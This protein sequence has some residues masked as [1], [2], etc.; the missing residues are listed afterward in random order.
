MGTGASGLALHRGG[1]LL[2]TLAILLFLALGALGTVGAAS[3]GFESMLP[4]LG[5]PPP[6][7]PEAAATGAAAGGVGGCGDPAA[8]AARM[9]SEDGTGEA[10]RNAVALVTEAVSAY[11]SAAAAYG[12]DWAFLAGVGYRE[13]KHGTYRAPGCDPGPPITINEPGARGPMQF[14]GGTWRC[15]ADNRKLDVSGPPVPEGETGCYGTDGDGDGIADPWSWPDAAHSA[16]R[17][18]VDLGAQE[19]AP[20]AA[21][22]YFQGPATTRTFSA[23]HPYVK[24]VMDMAQRYHEVTADLVPAGVVLAGAATGQCPVA[25]QGDSAPQPMEQLT[26]A[27]QRMADA[28]AGCLGRQWGITCYDA[29]VRRGGKFEHPRGRACDFMLSTGP[30]ADA[31]QR[32]R[33]EA[34]AEWIAA[35]HE[36]LGILYVIWWD[37]SWKPANGI[38]PWE[39]WGDYTACEGACERN[40]SSDPS[41]G[42]YNHI[43]VSVRLQP[44]DPAF[45]NCIAGIA[46]REN[47]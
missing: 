18:L 36:A 9:A 41:N 21:F 16:A 12:L 35:N 15:G 45:A 26:P 42:H 3:S 31:V 19:D 43:H 5:A 24:G 23:E 27:T 40:P 46:C 30:P 28:V 8:M 25:P 10:G 39:E 37:R 34:V 6:R 14:L 32:A 7:F 17:Y 2:V 4:Y 11:C 22:R 29:R 47:E 1:C 33:G 44:G 38:I 20:L 13:C